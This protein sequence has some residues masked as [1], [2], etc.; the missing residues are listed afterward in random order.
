MQNAGLVM[1]S[2]TAEQS[3][4]RSFHSYEQVSLFLQETRIHVHKYIAL[5]QCFHLVFLANTTSTTTLIAKQ[6]LES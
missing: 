3:V 4:V 5:L 2:V 6:A 1:I